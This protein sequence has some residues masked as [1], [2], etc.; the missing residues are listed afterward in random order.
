MALLSGERAGKICTVSAGA[1]A[2]EA[3]FYARPGDG[4][5]PTFLPDPGPGTRCQAL[6]EDGEAGARRLSCE[7]RAPRPA[8]LAAAVDGFLRALSAHA[9]LAGAVLE[10]RAER[11]GGP[12]VPDAV[13]L[14]RL[15][16]DLRGA[17][18][19]GVSFGPSWEPAPARA[20]V[21]V[22]V[23]GREREITHLLREHPAW[24]PVHL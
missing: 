10:T 22:G 19:I 14:G 15:A 13:L 8:D 5:P 2:I 23:R 18:G 1:V 16:R 6:R 17:S 3:M 20:A 4:L 11:L 12:L 21:C 9:A 24:Y 7:L